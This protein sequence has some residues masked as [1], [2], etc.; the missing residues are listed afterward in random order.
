MPITLSAGSF[1]RARFLEP[2]SLK[3]QEALLAFE[4]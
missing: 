2:F 3:R 1:L 4:R